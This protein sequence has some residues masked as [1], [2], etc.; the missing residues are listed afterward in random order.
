MQR[1]PH[2]IVCRDAVTPFMRLTSPMQFRTERTPRKFFMHGL[3]E[4]C[5]Q[6]TGVCA[7]STRIDNCHDGTT[8]DGLHLKDDEQAI[9]PDISPRVARSPRVA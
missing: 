4:S 2:A 9:Y 7:V 1:L 3:E 5:N 6:L 8:T